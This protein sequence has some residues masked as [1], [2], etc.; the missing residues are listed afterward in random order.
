M[1]DLYTVLGVPKNAQLEQIKRSY[2]RLVRECH[3]DINPSPSA[4]EQFRAVS[5][6]YS[7]LSDPEQRKLYDEFGDKMLEPGFDPAFARPWN[8]RA[9]KR[10]EDHNPSPYGDMSGFQDLMSSILNGG[11]D[12]ED[13][14]SYRQQNAEPKDVSVAASIS[15]DIARMGGLTEIS[16]SLPD[17]RQK[18]IRV[19]VR[20]GT[21]NGDVLRVPGQGISQ[22]GPP[23]DLLVTLNI[24][25]GAARGGYPNGSSHHGYQHHSPRN[26]RPS[27]GPRYEP[28]GGFGGPHRRTAS[29]RYPGAPGR[30]AAHAPPES[31]RSEPDMELV[32]PITIMEA[33]QGGII[34]VP[35]PVGT[36]R[37]NL[38]PNCAGKKVRLKVQ[39]Q[40]SMTAPVIILMTLQVVLPAELD[41]KTYEAMRTIER[42]YEPDVRKRMS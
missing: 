2:R 21:R 14:G 25:G 19:R 41:A 10:S 12:E 36:K 30:G 29:E 7:V 39:S 5:T 23:G 4:H 34:F 27:G 20:A 16:Y 32:V 8:Y 38:P 6:A 28:P 1:P 26:G 40:T 17:G 35:T 31:P 11:D 13:G 15:A 9:P 33:I 18:T 3:P 24:Q 22:Y 42:A 37:I